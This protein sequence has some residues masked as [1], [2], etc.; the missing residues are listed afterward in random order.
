MKEVD[1]LVSDT[2]VNKEV[3]TDVEIFYS[4]SAVVRIKITAPTLVRY[5]GKS[6]QDE[7]FPDG[8]VVEFYNNRKKPY[9]WLKA[10][11][12]IRDVLKKR[13]V[14]RGNVEM[15]NR[16]DEKLMT[17]ELIWDEGEEILS[18]EKYVKIIQPETQDTSTGFGFVTNQDFTRFEIKRKGSA[19]LNLERLK[20][21]FKEKN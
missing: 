5:I 13:I 7:E 10:D 18:T 6:S 15:Y 16:K 8:L 4:D 12:G 1:A 14:T 9:S 11:Y 19:S 20:E 17:S 21:D 2:G 3:A